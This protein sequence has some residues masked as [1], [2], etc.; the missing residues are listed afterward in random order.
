MCKRLTGEN[1]FEGT[2]E[3]G[4]RVAGKSLRPQGSSVKGEKGKKEDWVGRGS[5]HQQQCSEEV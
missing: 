5:V 4:T 2:R 3:E 1:A